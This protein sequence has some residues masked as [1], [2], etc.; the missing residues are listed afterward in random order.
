MAVAHPSTPIFTPPR[1]NT[2]GAMFMN[3]AV[4]APPILPD[5][6]KSHDVPSVSG[7][8]SACSIAQASPTAHFLKSASRCAKAATNVF[9]HVADADVLSPTAF[10]HISSC[11]TADSSPLETRIRHD[12][13]GSNGTNVL[14]RNL[15]ENACAKS[16]GKVIYFVGKVLSV[17][18]TENEVCKVYYGKGTGGEDETGFSGG[19]ISNGHV[20]DRNMGLENVVIASVCT[21]NVT[22]FAEEHIRHHLNNSDEGNNVEWWNNAVEGDNVVC[23]NNR[24]GG[25]LLMRGTMLFWGTNA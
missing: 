6:N 19:K 23:W 21:E 4:A 11:A 8:C 9:I 14:F 15:S 18:G 20:G 22:D 13:I 12:S 7:G 17:K 16:L 2:G 10:E 1:Y 24:G 5:Y 25:I 3:S